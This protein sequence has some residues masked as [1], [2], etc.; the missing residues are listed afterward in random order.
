MKNALLASLMTLS[1]LT[2]CTLAE[3]PLQ[4]TPLPDKT[5][6]NVIFILSDDHRFDFMG[7][8]LMRYGFVPVYCPFTFVL[9]LEAARW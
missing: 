3:H 4:L 6:K 2:A 9:S 1:S 8:T 5:P 7:F